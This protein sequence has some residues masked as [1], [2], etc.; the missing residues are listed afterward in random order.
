MFYKINWP[1]SNEL[2]RKIKRKLLGEY[3]P[4]FRILKLQYKKRKNNK[5]K[6]RKS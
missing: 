4:V 1:D 3:H 6:D 5:K 2:N